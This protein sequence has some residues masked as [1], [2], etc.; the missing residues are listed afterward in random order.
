MKD[1]LEI[2]N[3][4]KD[5]P[6]EAQKNIT[7][8]RLK[9][10]TDIKPQWRYKVM[11]E[12]FGPVGFGWYYEITNKEIIEGANGEKSGFVDVKLF[13]KNGDDWSM[14]IEGTGGSSFV[15]NE[16]HGAY[17]SDEV[18]KM[19]LTDALSVAMA[20]IGVG[21]TIYMGKGG[22]YTQDEM[23]KPP[24]DDKPWLNPNTKQWANAV[25][26]LKGTGTIEDI[27]NA[28]KISK[29]N[30]EKIKEEALS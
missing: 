10:M 16:K 21:A 1:N 11:T 26:H 6:K 19:A 9:G 2:W 14:P 28:Y 20:K 27:K 29:V 24:Q 7:G 17:T 18:F 13:V 12:T 5:V 4:L 8:G 30:E 22:K 3:K 25:Q 23:P 15:A